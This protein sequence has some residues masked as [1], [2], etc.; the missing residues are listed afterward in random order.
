MIFSNANPDISAIH[1]GTAICNVEE[2][3]MTRYKS[4]TDRFQFTPVAAELGSSAPK[5]KFS[6]VKLD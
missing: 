1:S 4:A 5:L 3:T 6:S 2:W